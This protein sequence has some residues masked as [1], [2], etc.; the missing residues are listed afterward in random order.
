MKKRLFCFSSTQIILLS[1]LLVILLGS[2]LLSLPISS[3]NG[4]SVPYVDALFTATTA[5]CVT[6]LVTMPTFATWSFFGQAV[7]LLLIQIGGLGV[8]TVISGFMIMLH[9]RIS[10]SNRLL[11]QDAFNLNS[12]SGLVRFVKKVIFGTF[13]IEGVGAILY[14]PVFI[15]DFGA[16]GIWLSVFNS[17]SAFCNAGIDVI[18]ENSLSNYATNPLI[19]LVTTALIIMGGIGFIVWWDILRVLKRFKK[20]KFKCFKFLSLH[21]KIALSITFILLLLGTLAVF[22]FEYN[23]PKTLKEYSLFNKIQLSFFQSVTTRTAGF[24]TLPQQNLTDTTS[25]I[26]IL[27]MFIGGSP[28]GTA[29]GIKTVTIAVLIA[30]TFCTIK[31]K[32]EI[33]LFGRSI[34]A[35][36]VKRAIAVA[37]ISITTLLVSA[38]LLSITENAPLID[39]FYETASATATVGLSRGLTPNLSVFGKIIVSAT[40]YLGRIGPISLFIAF[41]TRKRKENIIKNPSEEISVG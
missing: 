38:L 2:A 35:D 27:L 7:I 32:N 1:F 37:G 33:A 40:M 24:F 13:I 39:I 5:T 41:N 12:F 11:I 34:S 16:K 31:N 6:G 10:I 36:Y 19:N 3:A 17:V 22:V 21:S 25:V 9:Q 15:R 23:N 28:V 14:M 20:V 4:E 26:S 8:I 18:A 29:G 30:A